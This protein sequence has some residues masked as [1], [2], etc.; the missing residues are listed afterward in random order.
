MRGRGRTVCLTDSWIP[1]AMLSSFM[2][3]LAPCSMVFALWSPSIVWGLGLVV[4][5]SVDGRWT[6]EMGTVCF[7]IDS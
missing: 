4:E 2:A 6:G 3:E 7:E 5:W 1:V